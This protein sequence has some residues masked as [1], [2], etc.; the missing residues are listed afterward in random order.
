MLQDL[1]NDPKASSRPPLRHWLNTIRQLDRNATLEE[2]LRAHVVDEFRGEGYSHK[3]RAIRKACGSGHTDAVTM[4][5]VPSYLANLSDGSPFLQVKERGMHV[6]ISDAS[7]EKAC[8]NGLSVLVA[9][10]VHSKAPRCIKKGSQLYVIHGVC[11]GGF[12]VPLL[13]AIMEKKDKQSYETVLSH[14]KTHLLRF[15]AVDGLQVVVD[16]EKAAIAAIRTVFERSAVQGCAFHLALAWNRRRNAFGLTRF[17]SGKDTTADVV[18]WWNTI[19]GLVFLPRR[20]HG[21]VRALKEPPVPREHP[22]YACCTN[23]LNYLGKTWYKGPLASLWDKSGIYDVRTTNIAEAFHRRLTVLLDDF[24]V[25][26]EVIDTFHTLEAECRATLNSLEMHPD[27][28]KEISHEA[29]QRR[30][31]IAAAMRTFEDQYRA[32]GVT[33]E[34]AETYC[35]N[36]ARFV[37]DKAF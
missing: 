14:L 16:Y 31:E 2:D 17:I 15:G 19:K 1:R 28:Q 22:A 3:K 4:D 13:Y 24:P 23:F 26:S 10:G 27:H 9:D 5:S 35:K 18:G 30:D 6:Y 25:L 21:V 37:T 12:D 32:R 8:K 29:L 33:R 34:E 11:R 7:V 36:M 20:L